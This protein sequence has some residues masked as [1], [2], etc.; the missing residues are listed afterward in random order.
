MVNEL[1]SEMERLTGKLI[2]IST[3][4]R[5]LKHLEMTRKKVKQI[6]LIIFFN[7]LV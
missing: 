5:T 4:W 6:F 2:F 3:L 7:Y 1:V